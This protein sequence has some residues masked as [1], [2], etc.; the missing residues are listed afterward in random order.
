MAGQSY[1]L[2]TLLSWRKSLFAK[3]LFLILTTSV[4]TTAIFSYLATSSA[5]ELGHGALADQAELSTKSIAAQSGPALRFGKLDTVVAQL[6]DLKELSKDQMAGALV[7]NA[8]AET[9]SELTGGDVLN[10]EQHLALARIA[11]E[12][13]ETA[14]AENGLI[15]ASPVRIAA[16]QPVL[17]AITS[18]WTTTLVDAGIFDALAMKLAFVTIVLIV[19]LAAASWVLFSQINQPLQLVRDAIM[20][21]REKDYSGE[22]PHLDRQD[23]IGQIAQSIENLQH[24]LR[25][26]AKADARLAEKDAKLRPVVEHLTQGLRALAVGDL[27]YQL[28]EPFDPEY[29]S[30]R[31]DY[32]NTCGALNGA[33]Q[34]LAAIATTIQ[35][36]SS[37]MSQ[38]TYE[39]S[40]RTEAQA[41][42]LEETVAAIAEVT[43]SLRSGAESAK[44]VDEIVATARQNAAQS[45]DVVEK[46]IDA[47][48]AIETSSGEIRQIIKVIEDIAFQTNLLALNAGVEA[49]RAGA[50]GQGFAVVASEIRALAQRSS[51]AAK[52]INTLISGSS[53]QVDQGSELVRET[54]NALTTIVDQVANISDLISGIAEATNQTSS[55]LNEIDAGISDLDR[56]T[57]QNAAMVDESTQLSQRLDDDGGDLFKLVQGFKLAPKTQTYLDTAA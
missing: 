48:T 2:S 31:Q 4:I 15:I 46:A 5:V 20:K 12:T 8:E 18:E 39:L 22:I 55:S 41:A 14:K 32:T 11:I 40:G 10:T 6:T 34:K 3:C 52:Q 49:A 7:Y 9:L 38:S 24:A 50:A 36:N 21:V 54:A 13:G 28:S 23:E 43:S 47:M 53:K 44:E 51:D 19:L 29:E 42:T 56:V 57:Q 45:G 26:S 1:S 33:M 16:D 27:T 25:E 30:L 17:G 35:A 37:A